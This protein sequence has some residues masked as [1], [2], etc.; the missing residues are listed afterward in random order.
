MK[1]TKAIHVTAT[2]KK[3]LKAF[4]ESGHTQAKIN[5]KYYCII[6]GRAEGNKFLYKIEISTP[7]KDDYGNRKFDTQLIE[8]LN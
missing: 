6:S 1:I 4:L 7:T 5:T 3:H 8:V 2:E